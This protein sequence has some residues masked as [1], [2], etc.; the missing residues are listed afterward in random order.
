MS[1]RLEGV[2]KIVGD[3]THIAGL[4][5]ELPSGSLNVLLGSTLAGKTTTMR[6]MAGLETPTAGRIR[7]DGQDVTGRS[8]RHRRVAMVYQQFINYP[9]FK[10]YDN[11]ASP[12][13]LARLDKAT[14]DRKVRHTARLLRI[15]HL[16]DRLPAELSGGQQQRCAIARALVKEAPLLLLDEPLVNLDYKLREELRAELKALFRSSATTVVYATTEPQEALVIGGEVIVL[17]EGRL[18]QKGPA[19]EVYH[20]PA[21][22]QVAEVFSDPPMNMI[23]VVIGDGKARA[24]GGFSL[25]LGEDLAG[26]RPGAYRLGLRASHLSTRRR[27]PDDLAF[28]AEVELAEVNG[29]ETF[30][31]VRHSGVAW[32]VQQEG[33]QTHRLGGM[34]QVFLDPAHLFVFSDRGALEVAP[35]RRGAGREVVH[36]AH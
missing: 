31:H 32:V 15:D 18:L 11:I 9:S 6:L 14:I 16:L 19:L 34:V 2:A 8:V 20:R 12:L 33:V 7:A 5:L 35:A 13:R 29:S 21:S 10:V 4:D 27:H 36:G 23:D 17:H 25:P 1:L 24:A 3:V 28:E 26:L 22:S 30:V